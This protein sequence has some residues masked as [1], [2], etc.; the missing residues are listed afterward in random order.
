M[1][2]INASTMRDVVYQGP[3]G[4]ASVAEGFIQMN[5]VKSGDEIY[6]LEL[7][8]GARVYG[9]TLCWGKGSGAVG[10]MWFIGEIQLGAGSFSTSATNTMQTLPLSPV[11]VPDTGAPFF[12]RSNYAHTAGEL[13]VFVQYYTTGSN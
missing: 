2:I 5:G 6:L 1:A 8:A 10:G 3:A 12:Y 9:A 4:N 11:T 7:P 13:R